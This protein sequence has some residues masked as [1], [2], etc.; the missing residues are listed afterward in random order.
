MILLSA[1]IRIGL[2]TAIRGTINQ[3]ETLYLSFQYRSKSAGM[4]WLLVISNIDRDSDGHEMELEEDE[5]ASADEG[6]AV[7][8]PREARGIPWGPIQVAQIKSRNNRTGELLHVGWGATCGLHLDEGEKDKDPPVVCKKA[9]TGTDDFTRRL[10]CHWLILGHSCA[11]PEC[12]SNHRDTP[13]RAMPLP[14][15][16]ELVQRRIERFGS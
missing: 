13:V 4:C 1:V 12:R 8:P 11:G 14:S 5:A 16:D 6:K 3:F 9:L 15:W 7:R 2:G 10:V